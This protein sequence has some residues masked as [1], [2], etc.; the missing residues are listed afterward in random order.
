MSASFR[1]LVLCVLSLSQADLRAEVSLPRFFGDNMVLQRDM[2]LPVW[3]TAAP[4]EAVTVTLGGQTHSTT[5]A[6]DG[7]WHVFLDPVQE[8]G[9]PHTLTVKGKNLMTQSY[10]KLPL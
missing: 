4:G 7:S 1:A 3:G 10:T 2:P 6:A 8:Y 5:A 9:G